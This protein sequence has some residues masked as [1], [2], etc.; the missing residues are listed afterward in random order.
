[1][2]KNKFKIKYS[3]KITIL[4]KNEKKNCNVKYDHESSVLYKKKSI[5][6]SKFK[7]NFQVKMTSMC[8]VFLFSL[9]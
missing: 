7:N 6:S 8:S 9:F 5:S 4:M 3:E 2:S 1:M